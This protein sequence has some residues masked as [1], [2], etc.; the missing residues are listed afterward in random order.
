VRFWILAMLVSV[1]REEEQHRVQVRWQRPVTI[2]E[3]RG[4]IPRRH[5]HR[6][7]GWLH[8]PFLP[9]FILTTWP[10]CSPP[11]VA[12]IKSAKIEVSFSASFLLQVSPL[13][14]FQF[15]C[16][17]L[18]ESP[19]KGYVRRNLPVTSRSHTLYSPTFPLTV[20][21][22]APGF[23]GVAGQERL[24]ASAVHKGRYHPL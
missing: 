15:S 8:E 19:E 11:D 3:A 2:G 13:L 1:F 24:C 10:M 18:T 12:Q 21:V 17:S 22:S 9:A 6:V 23:A 4:E 5:R 7:R 14:P 16:H 20:D